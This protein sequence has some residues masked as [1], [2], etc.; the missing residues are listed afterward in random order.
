MLLRVLCSDKS[1]GYVEDY[2]LHDLIERGI[3]VAFFQPGSNEWVNAK[4]HHI[5]INK[6]NINKAPESKSKI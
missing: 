1:R 5:S 3:V 4:D 2:K 6:N